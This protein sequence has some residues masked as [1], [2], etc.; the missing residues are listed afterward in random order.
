MNLDIYSLLSLMSQLR[1]KME[2]ESEEVE[3]WYETDIVDYDPDQYYDSGDS[4]GGEED[5]DL[6]SECAL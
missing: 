3:E 6:Q 5:Y 4:S 1:V 2:E